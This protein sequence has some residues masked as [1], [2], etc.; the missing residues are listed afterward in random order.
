MQ[1]VVGNE[2]ALASVR[3]GQSAAYLTDIPTLLSFVGQPP[4]DLEVVGPEF[5]PGE[6]SKHAFSCDASKNREGPSLQ[7]L[8][9]II[10]VV[11][12][13]HISKSTGN[14]GTLRQSGTAVCKYVCR[15][16]QVTGIPIKHSVAFEI[17]NLV[18][19]VL[20]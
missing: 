8:R 15:L 7:V 1:T 6:Y 13:V 19:V 10:L 14:L 2:A 11:A 3:S 5:G 12:K 20:V 4:C 18:R 16:G 9:P 17:S